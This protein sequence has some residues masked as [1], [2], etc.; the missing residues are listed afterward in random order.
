MSKQ[1]S[2]RFLI[3]GDGKVAKHFSFY[4]DVLKISF[5]SWNRKQSLAD[6]EQKQARCTHAFLLIKDS[7]IEEFFVEHF[8]GKPI[9]AIHFSGSLSVPGILGFHPLM[10]FGADIYEK[11]FYT[12]IPFITAETDKIPALPNEFITI[13]QDQKQLYHALCVVCGNFPQL[14]FAMAQNQLVSLG[15][16]AGAIHQYTLQSLINIQKNAANQLT[17]PLA[18]RDQNTIEKNLAALS[19][20]PFLN[21]YKTMQELYEHQSFQK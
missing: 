10:T 11:D 21:L 13:R 2:L 18:R 17:G 8:K 3:I 1:D 19:K 9:T 14:I 5:C 12:Q 4:V 6:L 16:P 15:L 7:A 20:T